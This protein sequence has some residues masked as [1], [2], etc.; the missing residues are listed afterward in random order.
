MEDKG[1]YRILD[2]NLNRSRE[3]LRVIEDAA[4]FVYDDPAVTQHT[5][6]CRAALKKLSDAIGHENLLDARDTEG[7][8]G[9]AITCDVE[10][11]RQGLA[12]VVTAAVKRLSESLRTLEEYSKAVAPSH[13]ADIEQMRYGVY[14]LEKRLVARLAPAGRLADAAVY[15]LLTKDMTPGCDVLSLAKQVIDGGADIIQMREKTMPDAER[16]ELAMKLRELT[17]QAGVLLIINDRPDLAVLCGAD[18]VH[19]GQDD[20]PIA[21]ARKIL[22]PGMIIGRSTHDIE[23]ARLAMRQ[24]ADYVAVGPMFAT[25]TKD[26]RPAGVGL[27]KEAVKEIMV[28]LVAIGGISAYNVTELQAAG[29]RCVALCGEVVR[30][31]NPVEVVRNFKKILKN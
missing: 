18:G 29:A 16:L 9:T 1:I 11:S 21:A 14:T 7:D 24:G 2:A 28:P 17:A 4:R 12:D 22:R 8:V 3:A 23:Q 15:V 13:A 6:N 30:A 10:A 5:K 20:L 25:A 19:V 27:L 31:E 26:R